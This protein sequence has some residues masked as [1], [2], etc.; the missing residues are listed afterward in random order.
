M[1]FTN[2]DLVKKHMLEHELGTVAKENVA[3]HMVGETPF[4]LPHVLLL[5]GSEKIKAKETA[6]PISEPADFSTSD[7]LK[8]DHQELVPDTVVVASD[9][10]LGQIYVEN[11]DYTVDYDGGTISRISSGAIPPA[12]SAVVWY[13]YFRVYVKDTDYQID[14]ARGLVKRLASGDIEDGQWVLVDYTVEMALLSDEVMENAIKEAHSQVLKYI[15]PSFAHSTDGSLAAAETYLAVSILCN[16]K[17]M[18][19]MTQNVA[20]GGGWQTHSLSLA[21]SKMSCAYRQQAFE[22]LKEFRKDT[23]GFSSPHAARS[24]R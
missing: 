17:A 3:C 11:V 7:N 21:W 20:A 8:L 24:N 23:G 14:Y 16:I 12:S 19:A 15:D 18:E 4:Q 22:I 5:S 1:G 10:S 6:T 2:L 9:S 13:L